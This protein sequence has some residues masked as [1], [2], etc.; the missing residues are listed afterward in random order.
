VILVFGTVCLDRVMRVPH[1]PQLGGY[2]G[3]QDEALFLGGEAANTAFA[4]NAWG[5][6]VVLVSNGLGAHSD[7]QALRELLADRGLAPISPEGGR[8]AVCDI[9]VTPDGERTMFGRGFD[10]LAFDL[11]PDAIPFREKCWF[12]AEPNMSEDSRRVAREAQRRGMRLYL[13]DFYRSDEWVPEG[14]WWQSSSDWVGGRG[15]RE[16]NL[17]WVADWSRRH[18]CHSVLSDGARGFTYSDPEGEA[19]FYESPAPPNIVDSTG[20]GDNFRAG[21]LF[22]LSQDWPVERCLRFAAAAGSLSCTFLGATTGVATV[23]Q[24]T[25][26][27]GL[28]SVW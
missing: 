9:Y 8:T 18:R 13:M 5:A 23:E 3:I 1:L 27:A 4:L 24:I 12:T 19:R 26:H 20:A 14:A 7:G 10:G 25:R 2:V 15:D 16:G 22:G 28:E 6:E 21:M 17:R 11:A